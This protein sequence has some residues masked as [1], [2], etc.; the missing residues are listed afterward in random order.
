MR[1]T[2]F[3]LFKALWENF[4][5][6]KSRGNIQLRF[7]QF[8]LSE[9]QFGKFSFCTTSTDTWWSFLLLFYQY[10]PVLMFYVCVDAH[11]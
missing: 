1:G 7:A 9:K 8:D 10:D 5:P 3:D 2:S 6:D 11:A 4:V